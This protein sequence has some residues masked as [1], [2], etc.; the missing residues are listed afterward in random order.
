MKDKYTAIIIDDES[1]GISNLSHSLQLIDKIKVIKSAQNPIIGKELILRDRPDLLF[2]DVEMPETNGFDLLRDL[3]EVLSWP[4]Q[5]IFYT[6]YNKYLLNALRESAFDYLLKPYTNEEF[7]LVINHFL[8]YMDSEEK[9]KPLQ[10]SLSKICAKDNSHFLIT[11]I[12]GYRSLRIDDVGY[13]EYNKERKHWFTI[14]QNQRIALKRNTTADDILKLATQF[15][16]I[17]QQQ[18]ININYLG[19]I[20][21]KRCIMLPPFEKADELNISRNYFNSVQERFYMI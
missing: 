15:T 18:I 12:K 7:Q 20:E 10:D 2:L 16:Q 3:K 19:A 4:M 6:A 14:I 11:T 5:V 17:N 1:I 13:F 21:G 8:N 9:K